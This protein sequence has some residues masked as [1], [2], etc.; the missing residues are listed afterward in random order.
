[1]VV[2]TCVKGPGPYDLANMTWECLEQGVGDLEI[3]HELIGN[4]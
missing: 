2:G 1:M 4:S 3:G